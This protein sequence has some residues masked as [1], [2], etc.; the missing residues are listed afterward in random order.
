MA[1]YNKRKLPWSLIFFTLILILIVWFSASIQKTNGENEEPPAPDIT[2][3]VPAELSDS[4]ESPE[5]SIDEGIYSGMLVSEKEAVGDDFFSDAA[6]MGNSLVEGFKLFSG[7]S[8]CDYYSATSLTV[9]GASSDKCV[10]LDN[11]TNGTPVEGLIQKPYGKI[12]ILL[13]INEIGFDTDTFAELY[14]DILDMV[15]AGQADCDIYIMGLTP[16]SYNKSISSE[17]FSMERINL[18]N[19]K[20]RSL[21]EEKQCYYLDLAS[22]LS[23]ED[24]YLPS[25]ETAD[26]VHFSPI[27]YE[28]WLGYLRTHYV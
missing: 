12:Y 2:E 15:I 5:P 26:G 9:M 23:G 7:L 18:Y 13:G 24:G 4:N 8:S 1:F 11:G 14:A 21:A 10:V 19:D 3:T 27:V 16:V 20:L 22:A 6:F 25:N 17:I 28:K